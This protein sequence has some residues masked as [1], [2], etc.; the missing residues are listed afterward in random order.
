M[1][2]AY[3]SPSK[4]FRSFRQIYFPNRLMA[5]WW[6]RHIRCGGAGFPVVC[7]LSRVGLRSGSTCKLVHSI[8]YT[9]EST[10]L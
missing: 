4:N 2:L 8:P 3:S 5:S 1:H 6:P 9:D 7:N 10:F